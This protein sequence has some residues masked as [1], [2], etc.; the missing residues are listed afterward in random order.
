MGLIRLAASV[1]GAAGGALN[2]TASSLWTEYFESGD[3][4][5][6]ILMK[7][8]NKITTK[9]S[10][11]RGGDDNIITSGSGI[12]VQ[13]NQCMVLV[14]NGAIVDFCAEPG[15][16]TFDA[17]AAP[18]LFA[19]E[20]K[21]LKA[22][23]SSLLQQFQA[24]GQR[25]NT[26]RVYYINLGEI[27]GFKWGSGNI[28]FDH[29]ERDF[30]T[31][32][33]CWHIATTLRGNGVYSIQI[34]D[35][36]KFFAVLGAAKAGGDANGLITRNDIELQI[37]TEAIAAIR[38]GVGQLSRLKIGYTDIAAN[39][40]ELTKTVDAILDESWEEGRG[41]S[42][43]R[44]AIGMMDVDE[45]S[46]TQITKYQETKGYSDP[47]MLGAYMGMGQTQAMNTA[48]GNTAGA[49]TGFAGLGMMGG[50]GGGMNVSSLMQ[51]GAMQ[52]QA[53][54]T[55]PMMQ[56]AP[57]AADSWTCSCGAVNTGKFCAECGSPKPVVVPAGSWTCSCGHVNT[58]KFCSECGSPRPAPA[59][60]ACP[61]CGQ[62][63]P[64]PAN[65]P[66]FC[67][68]CGSRI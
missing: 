12:D 14:E 30:A 55:Q 53:Q 65:P 27:Q 29:W 58:G 10:R 64:D 68:N 57:P 2:T 59:P 3:M 45:Q 44:I 61:K 46:R 4:S 43:Y 47:S 41:I 62:E 26:Q 15:R 49:V 11:N 35:P 48:A 42:M 21:G 67:P 60:K 5:G 13:E 56:A 31:D 16:Y 38:Q 54:Q 52:Q 40:G 20:N 63:F 17:S 9:N 22:V 32:R 24:G 7:R 23:A 51:Q 25:T 28:T 34:T 19:G 33:P 8:G 39:E 37:K 66:K 18:S 1:L 36:A 6:G 50:M